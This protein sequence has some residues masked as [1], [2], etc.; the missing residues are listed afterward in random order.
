MA[1]QVKEELAFGIS[2]Q[3]KGWSQSG[4]QP[5][6]GRLAGSLEQEGCLKDGPRQRSSHS[7]SHNFPRGNTRPPTQHGQASGEESR[8]PAREPL[9]RHM[10]SL[11]LLPFWV[12]VQ[13]R[14]S[15]NPGR[16][17]VGQKHLVD[18]ENLCRARHQRTRKAT[19]G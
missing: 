11:S 12:S 13:S 2:L 19:T 16:K 17:N 5:G 8:E 7:S 10:Q 4:Q 18:Q 9:P 15:A 14:F 3:N 1:Q 6:A